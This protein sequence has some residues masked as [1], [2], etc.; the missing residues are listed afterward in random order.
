MLKNILLGAVQGLTEFLPVSSSG[1]LVLLQRLLHMPETGLLTEILL[2]VGTL[3]AVLTVFRKDFAQMLRHPLRSRT[4]RLLLLATLPAV[5]A[6]LV[7]DDWL[8]TAF[9]GRYLGASFLLTA[10]LLFLS[11]ALARVGRAAR[12]GGGTERMSARQALCMGCMQALAIVP[13]ISRSGATIV[14]G[15]AAGV[16]RETAARFSFLMS[17]VATVGS[18]A[19]KG[20]QLLE[21]VSQGGAV[22]DGGLAGI[23]AGMLA[24]GLSGYAAIRWMLR[25]MERASL[26]GFGVYLAALGAAVLA[27]W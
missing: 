19:F 6:A 25:L 13:G 11:D 5:A 21:A 24:A 18:V 22:F 23:A 20:K 3:A 27:L 14:G 16:A 4:A 12:T 9:S 17:A 7:A 1:H 15:L 8:E 10:G 26:K 2:H